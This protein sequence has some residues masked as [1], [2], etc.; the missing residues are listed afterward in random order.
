MRKSNSSQSDSRAKAEDLCGSP[1]VAAADH[2]SAGIIPSA[3]PSPGLV[4]LLDELEDIRRRLA[5]AFMVPSSY[6]LGSHAPAAAIADRLGPPRRPQIGSRG[7]TPVFPPKCLRAPLPACF[8]GVSGISAA[9]EQNPTAIAGC[10][11]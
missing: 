6:M 1:P 7:G 9:A 5:E 4:A 8:S 3:A 10:G 2:G 11:T